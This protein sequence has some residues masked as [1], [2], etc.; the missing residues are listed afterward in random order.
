[1]AW[2]TELPGFVGFMEGT[3]DGE[4]RTQCMKLPP[5]YHESVVELFGRYKQVAPHSAYVVRTIDYQS[6]TL[7]EVEYM[8]F[9]FG[10][11]D[12]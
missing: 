3:V 1:M 9:R 2:V 6:K 5:P 12:K 11:T 4:F 7:D 10:K 8:V